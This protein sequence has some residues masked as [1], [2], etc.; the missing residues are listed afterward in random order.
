MDK[1]SG[2]CQTMDH[3]LEG[4]EI[5]MFRIMGLTSKEVVKQ[6]QPKGLGQTIM[7]LFSTRNELQTRELQ[8]IPVKGLPITTTWS[9]I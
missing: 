6:A 8:N 3:F 2:T 1:G 7:P 9:L 5:S 4:N